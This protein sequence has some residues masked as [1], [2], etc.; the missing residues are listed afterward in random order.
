MSPDVLAVLDAAVSLSPADPEERRVGVA[1]RLATHAPVIRNALRAAAAPPLLDQPGAYGLLRQAIAAAGSQ[2]AYAVKVGISATFLSD[3]LNGRKEIPVAV[4]T[5][6][7]LQRVVRYRR[8][9][10]AANG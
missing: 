8:K 7:G 5:D 4:L 3:A 10:V 2:A 6:L 1:L 9:E